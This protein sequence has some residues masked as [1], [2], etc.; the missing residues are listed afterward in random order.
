MSKAVQITRRS[1][2]L[3][4]LLAGGAS[5]APEK[6]KPKGGTDGD[7]TGLDNGIGG[8]GVV[9]T[10]R[11]FGSIIV[12]GLRI[13]YPERVRVKID[14]AAARVSDLR[15]GHVARVIARKHRGHY[16]TAEIRIISE[17]VGPI[18]SID[19]RRLVVLGQDA[20]VDESVSIDEYGV[21]DWV[22]VSGLRRIDQ[23][24]DVSL[25]EKRDVGEARLAGTVV[26]NMFGHLTIGSQALAGLTD[27]QLGQRI[28]AR[29][30]LLDD[31]L[32][33]AAIDPDPF[34][35]RGVDRVALESFVAL[36]GGDLLLAQGQRVAMTAGLGGTDVDGR[37]IVYA[38]VENGGL[39]LT[40]VN[41]VVAPPAPTKHTVDPPVAS[42][43]PSNPPS[44][45]PSKAA[46]SH[47]GHKK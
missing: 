11:G 12:N 32:E 16:S 44:T 41:P 34:E 19:G 1:L 13:A 3:L 2:L 22:E 33:V 46:A 6:R 25:V 20:D 43:P 36:Q 23:T 5:A 9:G 24:L 31:V 7:A 28:L 14:G 40:S 39:R 30:R 38:R 27:A 15:V 29:G 35:L 37:A 42:T 4:A 18:E 17:V 8:T 21:G 45:A 10:I 47:L 26:R